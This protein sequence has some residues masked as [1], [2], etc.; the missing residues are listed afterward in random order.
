MLNVS[1]VTWMNQS[2]VRQISL[3]LRFLFGQ[4]VTFE[5][6]LSFDFTCT[7]QFKSF[8]STGIGFYLRHFLLFISYLL[9][10]LQ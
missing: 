7:C 3:L 5:C 1:L 2:S 4:N 9:I 10:S 8:F 6:V